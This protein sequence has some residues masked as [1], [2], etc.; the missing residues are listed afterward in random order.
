[1]SE[2]Q[3]V[4]EKEIHSYFWKGWQIAGSREKVEN[5]GDYFTGS[6]GSLRFVICRDNGGKLQAFHN[7]C[8]HHAAAVATKEGKC[9]FF[10]CP[11]H[12]WTYGLDGRLQKATRLSGIKNFSAKFFGL[13]PI[14]RVGIWGP[15]VL[16]N[17]EEV[18]RKEVDSAALTKQTEG[19][20]VNSKF[21]SPKEVEREWLKDAVGDL[22]F[23]NFFGNL[24]AS[25]N[26]EANC[27]WKVFLDV[28][29]KNSHNINV[30]DLPMTSYREK[31]IIQL[32][33]I[34]KVSGF[35]ESK[36]TATHAFI[37]PNVF[38]FSYGPFLITTKVLPVSVGKCFVSY[39][40]YSV[41]N[42]SQSYQEIVESQI[43]VITEELRSLAEN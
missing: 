14:S 26:W 32:S 16:I 20:I 37:F 38:L 40:V 39:D 19:I 1:M 36:Q 35:G 29:L 4:A 30:C 41:E 24:V 43:Q 12:G 3:A 8:R 34:G 27:N 2:S 7:V 21:V 18:S 9:D 15:F 42:F 17:N 11:Y 25:K 5:R 28:H 31:A 22:P 13:V 33:T 10:V 23:Q 6:I